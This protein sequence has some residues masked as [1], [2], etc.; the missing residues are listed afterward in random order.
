MS[1]GS[2]PTAAAP[3]RDRRSRRRVKRVLWTAVALSVATI[4]LP[5][6]TSTVLPPAAPTE[7][8]TVLLV[9]EGLHRGVAFPRPEGGF[10]EFGFGEWNWYALGH[11]AW[12][13]TFSTLLWPTRGCLARRIHEANTV[14]AVRAALPGTSLA[15]LVV[16]GGKARVLRDRL[17]SEFDAGLA[18]KVYR[19]ELRME[20]VP[21]ARSYW[22]ADNCSDAAADWLRELDCEVSPRIIRRDFEVR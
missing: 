21:H 6:W 12:H 5:G 2:I 22:F 16:D 3:P 10:V 13:D 15:P 1:T 4:V 14:D 18:E 11:E 9:A 19:P 8:T 17:Q 20:F 7:P